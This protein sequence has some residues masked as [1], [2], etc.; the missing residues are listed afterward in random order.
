MHS[1]EAGSI[2]RSLFD[3]YCSDSEAQ[4]SG[5]VYCRLLLERQP[6]LN[7]G[8]DTEILYIKYRAYNI[9]KI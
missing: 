8:T 2:W 7:L 9:Y 5:A 1:D 6:K 4:E 3:K